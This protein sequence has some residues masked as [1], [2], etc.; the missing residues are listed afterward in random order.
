MKI[1]LTEIFDTENKNFRLKPSRKFSVFMMCLLI[2]SF[3]WLLNQL[4]KTYNININVPLKYVNLPQNKVILND[5]PSS[6]LFLI[7]GDGFNLL[8]VDEES[9]IDSVLVDVRKINLNHYG[10]KERGVF[11]THYI[12][13]NVIE[14]LG[15]KIKVQ[16]ISKDTIS[17]IFELRA[18]KEVPVK[19]QLDLS[20]GKQFLI[21]GKP[22]I[23]PE[24][25]LI[26]G[27]QSVIERIT[28]VSTEKI[29]LHNLEESYQGKWGLKIP[30]RKVEMDYKQVDLT[31]DVESFTEKTIEVP[32]SVINLPDTIDLITFPSKVQ[33]TCKAGLSSF[34][35]I[36]PEAFT[37]AV[38]YAEIA[39]DNPSRTKIHIQNQP[40]QVDVK[41]IVPER[42]EYIL[43][44]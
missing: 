8:S 19:P 17:F 41:K 40:L 23:S 16:Q 28:E 22:S 27:P 7:E 24:K 14:Q 10:D 12:H 18:E 38:D 3:F 42:V 43:R 26:S 13:D 32:L 5:L 4:T 25:V 44:K 2:A 34:D 35:L 15:S 29:S 36:R 37:L 1:S 11:S 6:I 39:H 9:E 33:L 20:T 21:K 30:Y 31:V